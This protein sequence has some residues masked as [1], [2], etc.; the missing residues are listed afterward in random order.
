MM[1][2]VAGGSGV[3]P[4]PSDTSTHPSCSW[5]RHRRRGPR[6]AS[7]GKQKGEAPDDATQ[8]SRQVSRLQRLGHR[9]SSFASPGHPGGAQRAK[10]G[11][12]WTAGSSVLEFLGLSARLPLSGLASRAAWRRLRSIGTG[13]EPALFATASRSRLPVATVAQVLLLCARE[14]AP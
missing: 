13:A 11:H 10:V 5:S 7:D 8:M 6:K 1:S 4:I 12:T 14:R 9:L 2:A 3:H